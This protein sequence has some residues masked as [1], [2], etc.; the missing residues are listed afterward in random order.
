MDA[1]VK[2]NM[3]LPATGSGI[4]K[5]AFRPEPYTYWIEHWVP[6]VPPLFRFMEELGI[7]R[8]DL[9]TTFNWDVG[10]Y[11]FVPPSEATDAFEAAAD[12]GVTLCELGVV[13]EGDRLVKFMPYRR[14]LPPPGE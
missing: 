8:D 5:L 7:P 13:K 1:R 3:F 12:A 9:L 10:Y 11:V 2:V 14:I 6:E 4:S